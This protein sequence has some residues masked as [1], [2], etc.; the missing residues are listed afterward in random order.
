MPLLNINISGKSDTTTTEKISTL[1][2][3]PVLY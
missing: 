3:L 2:N 1:M